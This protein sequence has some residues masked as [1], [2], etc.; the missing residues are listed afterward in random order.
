MTLRAVLRG[1]AVLIA[2]LG[3]IDPA[4]T[5]ARRTRQ[6]L[7]VA[8]GSER[9]AAA[10]SAARVRELLEDD[11]DVRV[12]HVND[13]ERQPACATGEPC[14][15]VGDDR[16][17]GTTVDARAR[18]LG[19]IRLN[20]ET[21]AQVTIASVTGAT[22]THASAVGRLLV[23][24]AGQGVTGQQSNINVL[25]GDVP[26]GRAV[27]HWTADGPVT[28]PIDW[29]P[30]AAGP[31][32]LSV[33]T[34]RRADEAGSD[35]EVDVG[36]EV[37]T[38]PH[39]VLVYD[40]RPSWTSTFVRRAIE[41]DGRLA[42]R[43]AAR[44]GPRVQVTEG[45]PFRLDD[46]TLTDAS[47]VIVGAPDDL[48][49]RDV[50]AL[51]RY[52]RVRGGSLILVP[53]RRPTGPIVRLLPSRAIERLEPAPVRVGEWRASELLIFR[54]PRP[55]LSILA[56]ANDAPVVIAAASGNGRIVVSG[57]MD[58]W[59]YRDADDGAFDR[60]WRSLVADA[61]AAG[62]APL[63]VTLD[64]SAVRPADDVH[65]TVR[66]RAM[67]P[68]DAAIGV[69]ATIACGE[70]P[71]RVVRLWPT[72]DRRRFE[73]RLATRVPGPCHV[74]A[75]SSAPIVATATA[76]LIVADDFHWEADLLKRI[77][78]KDFH[79]GSDPVKG[80]AI[81][82]TTLEQIVAASGAQ[83]FVPGDEVSL[84][85]DVRRLTPAE[86]RPSEARVMRSPWWIVPFAGCLGVE[87][88]LRRRRGL[89]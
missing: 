38:T 66:V 17:S 36:V 50:D 62:G 39:N 41:Q 70:E 9:P 68:V 35:D 24:V 29:W 43:V 56:T 2:A 89:R 25:D 48:S 3:V 11:F 21:G 14:I 34:S 80:I 40:T 67:A 85:R 5:F 64:R 10:A 27:H 47:A 15:L 76:S 65:V 55:E 73:A 60:A 37:G 84:T 53:D 52:V 7:V 71:S 46:S 8:L 18:V 87:W 16:W 19:A 6:P 26:V 58:A 74:T 83:V 49:A 59:R 88:W 32:R 31:R 44:L 28:I 30:V 20:P 72:G 77:A 63:Q 22:A 23:E 54:D 86:T 69:G 33:R 79:R 57:A 1:V 75:S 81:R 4:F 82:S 42:L 51:E 12:R 78:N 13:A 45:E 61:A